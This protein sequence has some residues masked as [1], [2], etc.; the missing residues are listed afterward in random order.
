M[1]NLLQDPHIVIY[2]NLFFGLS[3]GKVDINMVMESE[4]IIEES[5]IVRQVYKDR[6]AQLESILPYYTTNALLLRTKNEIKSFIENSGLL[7]QFIN[8]SDSTNREL[9]GLGLRIISESN[10]SLQSFGASSEDRVQKIMFLLSR[11]LLKS[12]FHMIEY[13][14]IEMTL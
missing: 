12:L 6:L 1:T 5:V 9:I 4:W 13:K 3:L 7:V 14:N 10:I 11:G 2:D 8:Y